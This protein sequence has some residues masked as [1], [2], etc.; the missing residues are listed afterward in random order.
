MTSVA[1][2]LANPGVNNVANALVTAGAWQNVA[3]GYSNGQNTISSTN[4]QV[5]QQYAP[6]IQAGTTGASALTS[7]AQNGTTQADVNSYF[8]PGVNYA[9]GLAENGIQTGAAARGSGGISQQALSGI[10]SFISGQANQNYTAAATLAQNSTAQKIAAATNL[11][12]AGTSAL[13]SAAKYNSTAASDIAVEQ[14]NV[15]N[16]YG[17]GITGS[18]GALNGTTDVRTGRV[19][20]LSSG[21]AGAALSGSTVANI[22]S[23]LGGS[24]GSGTPGDGTGITGG[25]SD[26]SI[27]SPG[28]SASSFTPTGIGAAIGNAINGTTGAETSGWSRVAGILGGFLGGPVGAVLASAIGQYASTPDSAQAAANIGIGVNSDGTITS[29]GDYSGYTTGSDTNSTGDTSSTSSDSSTSSSESGSS[30]SSS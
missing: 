28:F 9:T 30:S 22:I 26:T 29:N 19:G 11:T 3:N 23:S 14:A 8:Q 13:N 4:Q 2:I 7:L 24:S 16:A 1:D 12:N 6:L 27:S 15:G 10:S 5:Q 17:G 21:L 20:A 25:S 18:F